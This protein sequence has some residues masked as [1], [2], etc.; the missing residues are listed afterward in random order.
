[1]RNLTF[2]Q[3]DEFKDI[4]ETLGESLDITQTQYDNL[5][6][7]Y[8]AVGEYLENDSILST[9][10]PMITPQ[11]SLR[12]GTIIQPINPQDDLDVDLVFRLQEKPVYWTQKNLK[13]QV[14]ARIKSNGRYSTMLKEKEGGR[15]CWTLLYRDNA[16][17][18]KERYHM[19]IL[20]AVADKEYGSI[21]TKLFAEGY[22]DRT[23]DQ[24]SIRITDKEAENYSISTNIINWLK[25]NPDGYALWFASRCRTTNQTKLLAEAVV[26]FD[27]YT[28]DKTVL[29]RIVQIL[30]RHRDMMFKN[31]K[32]DKPISIIITTLAAKAYNGE[33]NIVDGLLNVAANIKRGISVGKNG[34]DWIE[35]PVNVEENFADKWPSHP[36]RREN[37]YKW[38]TALQRDLEDIIN[39]QNRTEIFDSIS[40]TFGQDASSR[41]AELLSERR[42]TNLTR[43]TALLSSLGVVGASGKG[44]NTTN[45][46]Y[47]KE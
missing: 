16:E 14:G 43:G 9:Y 23:V 13:D 11:G 45:T 1:M 5:T 7:S 6:K 30:K 10:Q 47:G 21:M 15:R 32:D 38:V 33:Q 46:F 35:N 17:N 29:Q 25:S 42:K 37:F 40:Q 41:A 24:I 26:P 27:R 19:D 3:K 12:L 36:R 2:E 39:G 4:I 22:S 20:P 34:E 31:D 44:L 28:K 8:K 18:P